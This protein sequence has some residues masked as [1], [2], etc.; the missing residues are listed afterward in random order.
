MLQCG[1]IQIT[2]PVESPV[3][4]SSFWAQRFGGLVNDARDLVFV[5]QAALLTVVFWPAAIAL[6]VPGVF[7]WYWAVLYWALYL[8]FLG[9]F[10]LMLHNTSH[11]TLFRKEHG[12]LN[13]YIPWVVG[14]LLGQ[15]PESYFVHHMAVHHREGNLPADLSSTMKY[16]RDSFASFLHYYLTFLFLGDAQLVGYLRARG[17]TKLLRRFLVG[18]LVFFGF[19]ALVTWWNWRAGLTVF[20]VPTVVTRFLLMAGNW[21]QHAFVDPD[22][23]ANDWRTV[24]TFINSGYNHRCFNDGYHLGHH[25]KAS[26]H[27]LDMP[28]DFAANRERLIAER[29]LVFRRIDYFVIFLLLMAKR[30]RYLASFMVDLDPERPTTIDERVALLRH[31]LQRLSPEA[32][33]AL[34]P[35]PSPPAPHAAGA[36]P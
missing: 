28:G 31:R 26:R 23:P 25:L 34:T 3:A 32:L 6:F 27:W 19:V 20:V 4:D 18:E 36:A 16:Q 17:R 15:S 13:R 5:R 9:P 11:R 1:P 29:S 8:A 14:P 22:D 7:R 33:A 12:W 2:D 10:I 21:A 24:T 35:S 30:H